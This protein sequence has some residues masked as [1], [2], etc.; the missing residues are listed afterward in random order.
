MWG[1]KWEM[2]LY[3]QKWWRREQDGLSWLDSFE[4]ETMRF[5]GNCFKIVMMMGALDWSRSTTAMV[6]LRVVARLGWRAVAAWGRERRED[7]RNI[8]KW[9]HEWTQKETKRE[10]SVGKKKWEMKK[11]GKLCAGI[12]KFLEGTYS[13]VFKTSL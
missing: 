8:E 10:N 12:P 4:D 5:G 11:W 7:I 6:A 1:A 3:Q 9:V 13:D 2:Y